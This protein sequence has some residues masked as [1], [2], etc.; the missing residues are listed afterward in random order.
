M[1]NFG[2]LLGFCL[3]FQIFRG[4]LIAVHYTP[5]AEEAFSSVIH[6]MRNVQGGWFLRSF[7]ANEASL[8]FICIYIHIGRG[9]FY[10][11]FF[12]RWTWWSGC[13]ILI[14]LIRVAFTGYVLPWGQIS[15][16]GATVITN[17]LRA[18]PYI[19]ADMVEYLWGGFCVGDPTLKRFYVFHLL[20]PFFLLVMVGIHIICLHDTGSRNPLGLERDIEAIP[21]HRYYLLR[22]L[23]GAVLVFGGL[24]LVCLVVPDLFLDPINFIPADPLITPLHIQPE[25]YFL[26]AYCILRSVPNKF[27]GVVALFR[28]VYCLFLLPLWPKPLVVGSQMNP[29]AICLFW[30]FVAN[31]FVLTYI[32]IC[33]IE[34]PF[35]TIGIFRRVFYFIFF[36]FYPLSWY[37]WESWLFW[38]KPAKKTRVTTKKSPNRKTKEPKPAYCVEYVGNCL[39]IQTDDGHWYLVWC[40]IDSDPW[41]RWELREMFGDKRIEEINKELK[42]RRDQLPEDV[43]APYG[44][45]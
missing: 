25:W 13:C 24:I 11:S 27:W 4:V 14:T 44:G 43:K 29:V 31:F 5:D 38:G 21:F 9:I 40:A 3:V 16:W 19:G 18:I 15:F 36:L 45:S 33:P 42:K 8:F 7:H 20:C 41:T 37:I 10:H 28:S 17:L 2:S 1:W 12:L 22:D 23:L 32:G 34:P 6:I 26:F 30:G 39:K 35:D